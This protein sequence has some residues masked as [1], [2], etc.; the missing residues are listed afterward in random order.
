MSGVDSLRNSADRK[1]PDSS[2]RSRARAQDGSQTASAPRRPAPSD[3]ESP[4]AAAVARVSVAPPRD[5]RRP[6]SLEQMLDDL[7]QAGDALKRSG[8]SERIHEYKRAVREFVDHVVH[9]ALEVERTSSPLGVRQR[10]S[11]LLVSV[12]D[13]KLES[14]ASAVLQRQTQQML[15]VQRIDE[16]NGLLVDLIS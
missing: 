13:A 2:A 12:I 9:N 14:L 4:F 16:I 11:Y 7:H 5:K 3:P 1:G 8:G 6:A 15:I 10:K